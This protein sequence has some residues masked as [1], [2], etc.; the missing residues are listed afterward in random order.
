MPATSIRDLVIHEDDMVVGTHGRGFW[1]LDDITPLRQIT[2]EVC[3][4]GR[5]PVRA[6]A[7]LPLPARHQHGYAAAARGTG[8]QEP[9]RWRDLYYYLKSAAAGPVTIEILDSAGKTVR[10]YSSTD[11]AQPLPDTLNVPTFW[12]RPFQPVSTSAGMHRF[13]WDLH[14]PP[15]ATPPEEPS[16]AA[17]PH[18]TPLSEGV[19]LPAGNYTVKLTVAGQSQSQ[20]LVVK[21]DPRH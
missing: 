2:P 15:P 7:R 4:L 9:A 19:W 10:T 20:P 21:P 5:A 18:D 14:G 8:R 11:T 1:I 6:A 13:V 17:I 12:I 16:I 3:R